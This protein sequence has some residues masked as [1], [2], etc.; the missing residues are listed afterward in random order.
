MIG[1]DI[2][3]LIFLF[4]GARAGYKKGLLMELISLGA[5]IVAIVAGVKLLDWG[6]GLLSQYINGLDH[7]M[8]V[9]AFAVIFIG[10][11]ILLNVIGKTVKQILDMTLLGSLDDI[12]G[13][14]LGLIKWAFF[15]SIIIWIF[16]SIMGPVPGNYVAGSYLFD[17]ISL[18][19]PKT[20]GLL[21]GFFPAFMEMFDNSSEIINDQGIST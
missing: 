5:F 8:P 20:F 7:L 17:T 9:I 15:L 12:A 4:I 2:G 6:I 21:A 13:G 10:V 16:E 19:A 1:V 3:I 14:A 18:L 11:I